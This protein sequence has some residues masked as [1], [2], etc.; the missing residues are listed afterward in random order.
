[1]DLF[2]TLVFAVVEGLTEFLPV[3]S[4]GHLILTSKLLNVSQTDF[5]KTFEIAIQSGAIL[6]IIVLFWKRLLTERK[7]LQ[8]VFWAFF[9]TATLG[10]IFYKFVKE[11]LIGNL[12]ITILALFI[13]GILIII[14]E[15][16]FDGKERKLKISDLNIFQSILIGIAQS[17]SM[18]PG[19]SRSAATII[20]GMFLGLSRREAV[21]FSFLLAIPTIM[22]ATV[23]DLYKNA[24]V[25]KS[26]EITTLSIGFV[27]SFFAALIAVK[28]F[29]K[30]VGSNNLIPFGIYRIILAIVFF[31]FL[32]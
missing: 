22:S 13:G 17:I 27:A 2:Q 31:L 10:F 1:M 12:N 24:S 23:Y 32:S 11:I 28:W 19:M 25:F 20:G 14:V 7:V 15:K 21:E 26:A 6:S 8:N 5:V 3:S 4:T 18:I 16:F 29:V 9:P 30:Y